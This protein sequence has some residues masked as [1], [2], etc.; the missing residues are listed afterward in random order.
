VAESP[1]PA[2]PPPSRRQAHKL[3]TQRALQEAALELFAAIGYDNTT[4]DEIADRAGVSPRTFFRYFPTKESV[5]FVGEYGFLQSFTKQYLEQP[6]SLTDVEALRDTLLHFAEGL[7]QRRRALLLYERAVASSTTLRGGVHDRQQEDIMTLAR[8]VA[9]RR[10]IAQP[11]D[12]CVLLATVCLVTY[13]RSLTVW[14]S[15]PTKVDLVTIVA[16]HF[17]LL[18]DLFAPSRSN[19]RRASAKRVA[20]NEVSPLSG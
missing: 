4:T 11:D 2:E 17:E 1:T 18:A 19:G 5:L 3:Q 16:R 8:A 13:R 14:L 20:R 6:A 9:E 7:R 10:G 12:A 15:G